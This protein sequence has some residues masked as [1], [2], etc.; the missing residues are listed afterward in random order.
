MRIDLKV[1]L[2]LALV[3][4]TS[5]QAR[6][7]SRAEECRQVCGGLIATCISGTE[8]FG[9]MRVACKRAVLKEC[10]RDGTVVCEPTTTTTT[11]TTTTTT[12]TLHFVDNGDGTVT[13][14]R[15]GLQ[16]EKKVAG[17]DCPHCVSDSYTASSSGTSGLDGTAYSMF[18]MNFKAGN[19]GFSG[20][21]SFEPRSFP[22]CA[23]F[24]GHCDW[25]LPTSAELLSIIDE[26]APGC[27]LGTLPCVDPIFGPTQP[28]VYWSDTLD[29]ENPEFPP[30]GVTQRQQ[31][32][33]DFALGRGSSL[34]ATTTA[35][36]RAVRGPS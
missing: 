12:T 5:L 25:R 3:T 27:G 32:A 10:R 33:V 34:D 8:D 17:A 18:L 19:A 14:N 6:A 4:G 13:D 28:G 26:A 1:L 22:G 15:T 29:G 20:M 11:S 9:D 30:N 35:Y 16:W 7:T 2:A 24:A 21:C 36:A 23:C 31:L